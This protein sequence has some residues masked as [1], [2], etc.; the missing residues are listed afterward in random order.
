MYGFPIEMATLAVESISDKDDVEA[1]WNWLLDHG[2]HDSGGP[3]IPA[4]M[5]G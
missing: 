3:V 1:A 5:W 4:Q 2:G